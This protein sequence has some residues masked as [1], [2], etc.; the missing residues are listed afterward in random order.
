MRI[1]DISRLAWEQVKRRKVVTGLCMAGIS[2][3]CA[4]II[5]ALSIGDS[6]QSYTEREI[7]RNFKMDEITVS[8]NGGIPS[9]GGGSGGSGSSA[10]N[11][12]LDPGRLTAQKLE[13]IKGLRHVTAAA[14]FQELGYIQMLTID[15][16]I[17]DVQLIGTDL[18]LLTKYDKKFKQGGASDLVG[19]A[20]LNYGATVGLIDNETRQRLFE[21]LSTDP[22]NNKLMEQYNSLSMLPTDMYKQQVQLQSFDPA[23]QT[24]GMLVSSPIQV[25]GILDNP[26]G[27]SEDMAMYDKKI[28]VSLETGERLVEQMKLS[29]GT[30]GQKGVYNSAIVKVD[31]TENI[32][33]LEK[34]IQKL[35]LT[36]STN[37][38]QKEALADTF[39]MVKKAALGIG[40]FILIIASI[41]IIV[42]MTMSTHQRRRQ[43]GIMKVLGANMGQIRN[44]FIT[45][46]ALLGMLG[47]LLGIAFSYLIVLG[48]NK[49]IGNSSGM[50]GGEPLVIYIPLMTLPVGI[51][52]AVMTG[53][54]SGIYPA[55]S[56]SRTNALTAIKRD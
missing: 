23:S 5:V 48:I 16:K 24:G 12:K 7:N 3:G 46:A 11:E 52:F 6:A 18:R 33:E 51:A 39:S 30:A 13:I 42:A 38:Y 49:L 26:S 53:V 45:E 22:Y 47:G 15:N 35:T 56:A 2:I 40:V 34:L 50:G 27:T 25:V 14:P 55:I 37:L 4:A 31:S 28:Y 19:M 32:V 17:T 9:Q 20:V 21:Q 54:L 29:S 43:I 44:M 36:T 41:S 1:S 8:P 10:A